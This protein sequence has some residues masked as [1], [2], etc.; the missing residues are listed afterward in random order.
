MH[1]PDLT[2]LPSNPPSPFP[3][4][5]P[6]QRE[7]RWGVGTLPENLELCAVGWLGDSVPSAGETPAACISRL[8]K[9]YKSKQFIIDGTAG[10]HDCELCSG[11]DDWYPGSRVGPFLRWRGRR[12]RVRGYGHFLIRY[13]EI[14]YMSPVLVLHYI[15]DHAY[16]PPDEWVE[17]VDNG[18]L[19]GPGDLIWA[20]AA[21]L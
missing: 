11:P 14:V 9:A 21:P 12:L 15:I 3:F 6:L 8:W 16:L 18:E 4:P 2:R 10:W 17:A 7:G 13:D 19:L 20:E 5:P 1:I